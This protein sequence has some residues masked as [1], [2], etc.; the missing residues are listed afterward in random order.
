MATKL[1]FFPHLRTCI[2]SPKHD[3]TE[4]CC[5]NGGF[6]QLPFG[7]WKAERFANL[8]KLKQCSFLQDCLPLSRLSSSFSSPKTLLHP[9]PLC[10]LIFL[11]LPSDKT[12]GWQE[13]VLHWLCARLVLGDMGFIC[14]LLWAPTPASNQ[15][16]MASPSYWGAN[17][18]GQAVWFA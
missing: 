7:E 4:L 2:A 6:L 3:W 15:M 13:A 5:G 11:F 14:H 10:F 17:R 18:P 12:S 1:F 9:L 8:K 16:V